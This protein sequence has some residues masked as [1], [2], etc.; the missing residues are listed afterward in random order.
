MVDGKVVGW[1]YVP[2]VTDGSYRLVVMID[3]MKWAKRM[4]DGKAEGW[5][6][7]PVRV[8]DGMNQRDQS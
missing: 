3:G 1:I 5:M 4:T 6:F 7:G 2:G 8:Y